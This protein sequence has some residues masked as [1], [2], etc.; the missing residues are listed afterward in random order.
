MYLSPAREMFILRSAC[1]YKRISIGKAIL[2][3]ESVESKVL[4]SEM[5]D[6][7]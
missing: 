1:R 3:L 4:M 6:L 2:L 5:K 7:L